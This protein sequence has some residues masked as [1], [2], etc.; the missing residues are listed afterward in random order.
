MKEPSM[1]ERKHKY[2]LFSILATI[3]C[4]LLIINV[5]QVLAEE[6][7]IDEEQFE[8]AK[9]LYYQDS[10]EEAISKLQGIID[11]YPSSKVAIKSQYLMGLI[12][13]DKNPR[14]AIKIF[15]ALAANF[16]DTYLAPPSQFMIGGCYQNLGRPQKAIAAY[17]EVIRQFPNSEEAPD[18]QLRIGDIL[19]FELENYKQ[20][21]KEYQSFIRN[22]PKNRGVWRAL[23]NIEYIYVKKLKD[24]K[25]AIAIYRKF[26][27][28]YPDNKY[29]VRAQYEIGWLYIYLGNTHYAQATKEFQKVINQFPKTKFKKYAQDNIALIKKGEMKIV[30]KQVIPKHWD[31]YTLKQTGEY[32][33]SPKGTI[34]ID[35]KTN[36]LIINDYLPMATTIKNILNQIDSIE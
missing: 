26:I 33:L 23:T 17:R 18:A 1:I 36:S 13:R 25:E 14:K 10:I 4:T 30:T 35:H 3:L 11:K 7:Q 5:T 15:A 19:E 6:N 24:I 16:L 27:T 2:L 21:V 29:I 8:D 20:A 28:D 32:H 31:L 9:Q 12:Y 34:L 22:Y